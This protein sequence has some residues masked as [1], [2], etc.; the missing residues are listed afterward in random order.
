[1]NCLEFRRLLGSDPYSQD[2]EMLAHRETCSACAAVWQRAQRFEQELAAALVVPV[3]EGLA[4]RILLAHT[5]GIRQRQ[6]TR[7]RSWMA[8][9]ASLVL[10]CAG[11]GLV[12]QQT[13]ARSL[14]A[15]S[16]AHVLGEIRS[17]DQT[18]ALPEQD[19]AEVLAARGQTM[20]GPAPAGVTY[21]HEC[22]V[23]GHP[24][25]HFVTRMDNEA[26]AALYMPHVM[27]TKPETFT[28]DGWKGREVQMHDG[29]LVLLAQVDDKHAMD[30]AEAGWRM[31]ID[32][33]GG[34][35][36]SER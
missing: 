36:L 14:P 22:N 29:T 1:M 19:V 16:V 24:A 9:A 35:L 28:R 10:A 30:V 15:M 34:A 5:T 31:A 8:M 26:V 32:G 23:G 3:P 6:V 2:P 12:W 11:G 4:D 17:M 20:H 27:G 13:E 21:V 18:V 25:A 33:P 7:R